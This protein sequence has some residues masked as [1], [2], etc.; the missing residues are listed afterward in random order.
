M[1]EDD[2]GHNY[3]TITVR[4]RECQ[5]GGLVKER[6]PRLIPLSDYLDA[7]AGRR[8]RTLQE[9]DDSGACFC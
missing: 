5:R 4:S 2:I 8:K 9:S 3:Q 1:V 7:K 6:P